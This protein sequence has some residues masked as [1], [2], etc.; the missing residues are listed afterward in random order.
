MFLPPDGSEWAL[1]RGGG[2]RRGRTILI[3]PGLDA[4]PDSNLLGAGRWV[5]RLKPAG[6][7]LASMTS[8]V[9]THMHMDHIGRLLIDRVRDR[10]CPA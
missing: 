5:Q 2:A 9:L 10:L 1:E 7:D 4:D 6:I 3:D 8:V